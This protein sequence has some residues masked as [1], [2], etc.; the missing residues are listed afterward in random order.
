MLYSVLIFIM[1]INRIS[2][3]IRTFNV[4]CFL[5]AHLDIKDMDFC[6]KNATLSPNKPK[7][8]RDVREP[9]VTR[10]RVYDLGFRM[11]T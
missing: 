3:R 1:M 10:S 5:F 7:H 9:D 6:R 2:L 8:P 11:L 4:E